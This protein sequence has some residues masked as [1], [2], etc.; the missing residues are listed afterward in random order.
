M[1]AFIRFLQG[2]TRSLAT[3]FF[4]CFAAGAVSGVCMDTSHWS[5][6]TTKRTEFRQ[7][8]YL[9]DTCKLA[10]TASNVGTNQ[11]NYARIIPHLITKTQASMVRWRRIFNIT[12]AVSCTIGGFLALFSYLNG[13]HARKLKAAVPLET[14]QELRGLLNAVP[15][16]IAVTGRV[17]ASH[18]LKCE[19]SDENAVITELIEEQKVE[20]RAGGIWLTDNEPVRN[21]VKE[22]HWAITD[23]SSIELPVINSHTASFQGALQMSGEYF[24]PIQDASVVNVLYDELRG[25]R[26]KGTR[27]RERCL[28]VGAVVTVIGE[29]GTVV[30]HG[31]A[32]F[33]RALRLPFSGGQNPNALMYVLKAPKQTGAPFLISSAPLSEIIDS[34]QSLSNSLGFWSVRFISI[35][36]GCFLCSILHDSL[37]SWNEQRVRDKLEKIRRQRRER[38]G[39]AAAPGTTMCAICMEAECELVFPSCGH[40][41]VCYECGHALHRCPLCRSRGNP[42]RVFTT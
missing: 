2:T 13:E 38:G 12:G 28:P 22:T 8:H 37:A 41:C 21:V 36:V 3:R 25:R 30:D 26:S 19:L 4:L 17:I 42:I 11:Q 27:K 14:L 18:P 16:I 1:T 7:L 15:L 23:K 40:L 5:S 24:T 29:L 10:D 34:V 9:T 32:D 39:D 33:K 20:I 35:G 31:N 6:Q